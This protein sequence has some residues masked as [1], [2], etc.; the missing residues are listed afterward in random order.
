MRDALIPR[1]SSSLIDPSAARLRANGSF[2][3]VGF[4]SIAPEPNKRVDLVGKSDRYSDIVGRHAV[5][6]TL[7]L[8][9]VLDGRRHRWIFTLQ[10]RVFLPHRTL[11]FREFADDL[12]SQV[13]F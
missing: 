1:S 9:V 2:E 8:V 4:S 10:Q 11:Q 3:P 7:R 12:G 5:G 13:G 6:R